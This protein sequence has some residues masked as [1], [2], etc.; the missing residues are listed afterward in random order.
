MEDNDMICCCKIKLKTVGYLL[1]YRV[2][3]G[4]QNVTVVTDVKRA[5]HCVNPIER[6]PKNMAEV[7][8]NAQ[9]NEA[10]TIRMGITSPR[11]RASNLLNSEC[12]MT[13]NQKMKIFSKISNN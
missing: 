13:I 12:R 2:E 8:S 10:N 7:L 1:V 11:A 9:K 3:N 5:R 6:A 4:L